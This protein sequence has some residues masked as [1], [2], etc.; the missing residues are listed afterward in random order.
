V[1]GCL[2]LHLA[3]D[4]ACAVKAPFEVV[5]AL[6]AAHPDGEAALVGGVVE[7]CDIEG[8]CFA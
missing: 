5:A 7:G 8:V 6:L 3:C 2:P 4:L 1:N